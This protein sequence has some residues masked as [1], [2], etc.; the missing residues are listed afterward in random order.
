MAIVDSVSGALEQDTRA[1]H[2]STVVVSSS[3]SSSSYDHLH[4]LL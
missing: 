2:P 1:R 3:S 4:N